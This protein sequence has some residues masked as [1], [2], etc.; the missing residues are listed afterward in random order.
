LVL[1]MLAGM[2]AHVVSV[3]GGGAA[4]PTVATGESGDV[5]HAMP[6]D[7][8]ACDSQSSVMADCSAICAASSGIL[9]S[10]SVR[11]ASVSAVRWDCGSREAP[12]RTVEPDLSPP[13]YIA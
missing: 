13:R 5:T 12:T 10:D 1:A 7:C 2:Q 11:A 3:A 8:A 4:M 6:M 9:P